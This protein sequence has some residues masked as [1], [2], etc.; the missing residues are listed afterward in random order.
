MAA[1]DKVISPQTRSDQLPRSR[2]D[3]LCDE[4]FQLSPG[5]EGML[6][7]L[8]TSPSPAVL[9]LN[10]PQLNPTGEAGAATAPP[11]AA[12]VPAPVAGPGRS[13]CS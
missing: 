1:L 2:R 7:S 4:D 3:E 6:S 13:L 8:A 10:S 5:T 12:R 11:P 9:A